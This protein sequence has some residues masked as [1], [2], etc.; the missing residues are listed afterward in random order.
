MGHWEAFPAA[1]PVAT[2]IAFASAVVV[3]DLEYISWSGGAGSALSPACGNE[4]CQRGF[5]LNLETKVWRE[6]GVAGAP[7]ARVYPSAVWTGKE[8]VVWGGSISQSGA[9]LTDGGAYNPT[10]DTW[11]TIANDGAPSARRWSRPIWTG[12]EILF[13]GGA[14]FTTTAEQVPVLGDGAAY[15]PSTDSWRSIS[16]KNAPS[17]RC[18]HSAVWTGT[19]MLVWGGTKDGGLGLAPSDT[20]GDAFAYDPASDSWR[21]LSVKGGPKPNVGCLEAWTG[22]EMLVWGGAKGQTMAAYNPASNTWRDID[23]S[24]PHLTYGPCNVWS[25]QYFVVCGAEDDPEGGALYDPTLDRWYPIPA[26]PTSEMNDARA[27]AYQ[28]DVITSGGDT[29]FGFEDDLN[30][31]R[32]VTPK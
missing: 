10:T 8:M 4:N 20:L 29:P 28:G 32:F 31:Y 9:G 26:Y 19:E 23:P 16:T 25:G 1:D 15:N 11:R 21:S 3:T 13:W 17:P 24:G 14:D 22:T 7:F 27:F 30:V 6:I 18:S 5:A 12:K 2:G